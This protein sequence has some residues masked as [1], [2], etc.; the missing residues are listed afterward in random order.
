MRRIRRLC[1]SVNVP[2]RA[3]GT[4]RPGLSLMDEHDLKGGGIEGASLWHRASQI[5]SKGECFYVN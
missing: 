2:S 3:F 1:P 5:T 4:A